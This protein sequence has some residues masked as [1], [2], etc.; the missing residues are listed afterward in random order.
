MF[1]RELVTNGLG[2]AYAGRYPILAEL[3]P[4]FPWR[5]TLSERYREQA[6]WARARAEEAE[7]PELRAR[8][9]ELARQYEELATK[10]ADRSL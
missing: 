10:F 3:S 5:M 7:G 4:I 2:V 1:R 8:W 6:A 9:L